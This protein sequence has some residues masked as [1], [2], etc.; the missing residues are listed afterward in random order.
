MIK[1]HVSPNVYKLLEIFG[2][3]IITRL[4]KIIIKK[5]PNI[6]ELKKEHY[7]LD[8]NFLYKHQNFKRV[9]HIEYHLYSFYVT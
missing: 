6:L 7:R 8:P 5:S 4:F 2:K 3:R 9:E 1:K